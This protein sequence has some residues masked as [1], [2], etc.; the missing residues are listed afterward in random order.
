MLLKVLAQAKTPEGLKGVSQMG[1]PSFILLVGPKP[2]L[3][4]AHTG[5]SVFVPILNGLHPRG[6]ARSPEIKATEV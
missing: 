6:M 2:Q 5:S 3:L 1:V 4:T